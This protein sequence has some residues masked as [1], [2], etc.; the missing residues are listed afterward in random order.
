MLA[1]K[2]LLD[3]DSLSRAEV[4]LILEQAIPF[5]ELFTRSV[6][7]VPALKGKSVLTLFYEPSTRTLSSFEIAAKRLSADVTNFDVRHSSVTKGESVRETVETLQAMRTDYI[8]V[9]HSSSGLPAAI[10]AQT[11][12]SV[13]NAG[14]GAHAHPT[15][16]LLDAFTIKEKFPDPSGKKVL[17]IGDILHSRVA[18]STSC[19]LKKLGLQV[20]FLGPGSLLPR[21][22]PEH[23]TRFTNY[24]EAMKWQPDIVY[25][26]R[27]QMERQN[28]PFFPSVREY[29]RLYGLSDARLEEV[30][31]RGL[32]L[33]HPGPVNRGVELCDAVM[34]YERSLINDQ[35]ENGIAARMSVLY[36]LKP[37]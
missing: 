33:M 17:I 13:I 30:R 31:Q 20:A 34:D 4:D 10:A 15:Q 12:A 37:A 11:K 14:D 5:K 21:N 19:I 24:D 9:R 35:V 25:L 8:V 28:A 23:I 7:K 26:L 27:V 36:C 2:D 16:A 18:R 1:R 32:Y 6:K 29:H 3:I 22:G